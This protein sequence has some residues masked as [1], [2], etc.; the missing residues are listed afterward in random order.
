M[1]RPTVEVADI[2]QAQGNRFVD[3]HR[4]R[5]SFQQ[6]KLPRAITRC[7][8]AALGGHVD[9]CPRCG[10][11]AISYNSRRNW[12]WPKCQAQARQRW[13]T[14]RQQELLTVLY[15]HVVFTLP[16]ELNILIRANPALLYNLLFQASAQ[17]LWEVA[18][19]PKHLGSRDQLLQHSAHLG[20]GRDAGCPA[21]PRTDPYV[22]INSYGSYLG[23]VAAKRTLGSG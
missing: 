23:W 2:I 19:D 18:A 12:H 3:R 13:L 21:P 16:H 20:R 8:T 5:L 4:N 10:H 15:F 7:R 17:T 22:S 6:L 1:S 14:A 11:Q 9:E